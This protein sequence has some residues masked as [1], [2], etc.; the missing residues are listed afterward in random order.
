MVPELL[1]ASIGTW[2]KAELDPTIQFF[3][4]S[5]LCLGLFTS[6]RL[7][8]QVRSGIQSLSKGQLN[9]ALAMGLTLGQA[10]RY[11]L[12]PHAY[13]II[14]PPMTSE[15]LDLVKTRRSPRRSVWWKWRRRPANCWIIPPT[16]MSLLPLLP[17]L[18]AYQRRD[19]AD[20]A[21]CRKKSAPAGQSGE[22]I[23]Y[24]FDWSSILP[25]LPYM[26]Q[27]MAVMR[28]SP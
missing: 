17:G 12:L 5:M 20:N 13:R 2:F 21:F 23:M 1:P 4:S 28:L 22:Q 26:L 15:M 24:E 6:A 10:Y 16:P 8:E 27:G 3:V 9:A 11:V 18:S 25:G 7:C 14:V 19:Y